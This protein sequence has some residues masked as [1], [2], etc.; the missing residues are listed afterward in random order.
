MQRHLALDAIDPRVLEPAMFG[1]E[2]APPTWRGPQ[3]RSGAER[4]QGHDRRE[5]IRFEPDKDDRRQGNDRRRRGQWTGSA[6][7]RW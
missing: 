5:E 3:R 1:T 2:S 7:D 6:H 4:R